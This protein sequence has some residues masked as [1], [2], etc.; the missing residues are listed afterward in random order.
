MFESV[1]DDP[2]FF[3]AYR[4]LRLEDKGLNG[5]L[6]EPAMR[7][8]LPN[9]NGSRV[10]DLG[11]GFGHF[12]RHAIHLGAT[13]VHA[14]DSSLRMLELA[15]E[16]SCSGYPGI[17]F[18][19]GDIGALNAVASSFDLVVSSMA[20]HYV[21]DL[22]AAMRA[23]HTALSPGGL[24]VF[25]VEHP[26]CTANTLGWITDKSGVALYWPLDR[27]ME[28]GER[29]TQWFGKEVLKYH[30]TVETYVSAILN[31]GF[32]LIALQEPGPLETALENRPELLLHVRRPPVLMVSARRPC[33]SNDQA[34]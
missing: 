10:L 30:R 18:E 1:Y 22:R 16:L 27:Y 23:V 20:L 7:S 2:E 13:S 31:E 24:F 33:A 11:C 34:I 21:D 15:Q 14:I 25:S 3:E 8:L 19:L 4:A 9:L 28:E 29:R 26:V 6:E 32:D 12:A 17:R 5:A